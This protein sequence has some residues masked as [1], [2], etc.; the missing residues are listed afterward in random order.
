MKSWA[1]HPKIH[2]AVSALGKASYTEEQPAAFLVQSCRCTSSHCDYQLQLSIPDHNATFLHALATGESYPQYNYPSCISKQSVPDHLP[3]RDLQH[4]GSRD[5]VGCQ[6]QPP[7]WLHPP[8]MA[9]DQGQVLGLP[10]LIS[11]TD[12][13]AAWL[14]CPHLPLVQMIWGKDF[15]FCSWHNAL[16]TRSASKYNSRKKSS[17]IIWKHKKPMC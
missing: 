17:S 16:P 1:Q 8:I 12:I 3:P 6:K 5:D 7:D 4:C 9:A 15:L 10:F 13:P 2:T 11:T 14:V